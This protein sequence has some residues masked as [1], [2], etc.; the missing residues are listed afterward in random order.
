MVVTNPNDHVTDSDGFEK[1]VRVMVEGQ[2]EHDLHNKFLSN[3][4]ES[5]KTDSLQQRIN[6]W[7]TVVDRGGPILN[8]VFDYLCIYVLTNSICYIVKL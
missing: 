3:Q 5:D 4:L 7:M 6:W 2:F 1:E 8:N